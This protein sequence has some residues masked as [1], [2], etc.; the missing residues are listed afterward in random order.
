M[1]RLRV[2]TARNLQ[3]MAPCCPCKSTGRCLSCFCVKRGTDCTNCYPGRADRCVNQLAIDRPLGLG[4]GSSQP[5]LARHTPET[6]RLTLSQPALPSTASSGGPPTSSCSTEASSRGLRKTDSQCSSSS[7]P[8]RVN[9]AMTDICVREQSTNHPATSTTSCPRQPPGGTHTPEGEAENNNHVL[10]HDHG[11][12]IDGLNVDGLNSNSGGD[13]AHPQRTGALPTV[14][15]CSIEI[16]RVPV[17]GP[18]KHRQDPYASRMASHLYVNFRRTSHAPS[19]ILRGETF[20]DVILL[21]PFDALTK[22]SFTGI[23]TCFTCHMEKSARALS[24]S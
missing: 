4:K 11:I 12:A 2:F 7:G 6:S 24:A 3:I 18:P 13:D 1:H 14:S 16:S 9:V 19:W 21:T 8:V 20:L 10:V 22:R 15:L 5:Q 17:P 23:E